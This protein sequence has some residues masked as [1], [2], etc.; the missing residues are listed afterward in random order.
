MGRVSAMGGS[1]GGRGGTTT[2]E[3][4]PRGRAAMLAAVTTFEPP[5]VTLT[6]GI[7]ASL[8]R[9]F[10][11]GEGGCDNR[12]VAGPRSD[13][14][15]PTP[16]AGVGIG[17]CRALP[18]GCSK[19][20]LPCDSNA[21]KAPSGAATRRTGQPRWNANS[22][23]MC[24]SVGSG[25]AT[26][27]ARVSLSRSMGSASNCSHIRGGSAASSSGTRV[28]VPRSGGPARSCRSR[29]GA[30]SG[31]F[32]SSASS[33]ATPVLACSSSA[34]STSSWRASPLQTRRR[35]RATVMVGRWSQELRATSS[36]ARVQS[37]N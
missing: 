17:A 25:V 3:P 18:G 37:S 12:G 29:R 7:G 1:L 30:A 20:A 21:V 36:R 31:H 24:A 32:L 14:G 35:A 11:G 16:K 22:A 27:I 34:L 23:A 9:G 10:S 5:A 2:G 13:T 15:T 4:P 33:S 26:T 8:G 19:P 6:S 28:K